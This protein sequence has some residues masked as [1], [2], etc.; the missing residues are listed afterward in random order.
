MGFA[1]FS[2]LVMLSRVNKQLRNLAP[3]A[4][5]DLIEDSLT[6]FVPKS[7]QVAFFNELRATQSLIFG[8]LV[9]QMISGRHWKAIELHISTTWRERL[10]MRLWFIR[11]GFIS[12]GETDR[13]FND[14]DT[15]ILTRAEVSPNVLYKTLSHSF[16]YY[17]RTPE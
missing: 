6:P 15:Y 10:R 1:D 13:R 5:K 11:L 4:V 3:T 9:L 12:N 14:C 8:D 2:S 16:F 17:Q 7:A